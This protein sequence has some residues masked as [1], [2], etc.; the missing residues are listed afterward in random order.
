VSTQPSTRGNKLRKVPRPAPPKG[1]HW[2][3]GFEFGETEFWVEPRIGAR[4]RVFAHKGKNILTGPDANPENYGSTFWTSPQSDWDWPPP[5]EIDSAPYEVSVESDG[6]TLT[7][8]V[9]PRFW[10]QIQKRYQADLDNECVVIT[11]TIRNCAEVSSRFAPWEVT[12]TRGGLSFFPAGGT[13]FK[14]P[15]LA[16]VDLEDVGNISWFRYDVA[17]V[18]GDQK[19]FAHAPRAW[20]AHVDED[21]LFVKTFPQ[22]SEAEQAPGEAM[23]EIYARGDNSYIELEQ[24]GAYAKIEPKGTISWTVRWYLRRLPRTIEVKVGSDALLDQVR[25]LVG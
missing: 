21:L 2:G 14:L 13:R 11:S 3:I 18:T 4:T 1:S 9:C 25:S 22:I 5:V 7:G 6:F 16:S 19:A 20:L 8:P 24:Q 23:I 15:H 12:R 17:K 10:V